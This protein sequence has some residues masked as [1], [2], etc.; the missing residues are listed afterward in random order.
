M[1]LH[2]VVDV[3]TNSSSTSFIH[4][5]EDEIQLIQNMLDE[6]GLFTGYKVDVSLNDETFPYWSKKSLNWSVHYWG[7]DDNDDP[8]LYALSNQLKEKPDYEIMNDL[9]HKRLLSVSYWTDDYQC[10]WGTK[11]KVSIIAPTGEK[12]DLSGLIDKISKIMEQEN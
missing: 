11:T 7:E 10:E 1:K 6:S 9:F 5:T 8:E 12:F 3:I 2:S 4:P